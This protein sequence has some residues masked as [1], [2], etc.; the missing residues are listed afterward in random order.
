MSTIADWINEFKMT[1]IDSL[2]T[3]K[4]GLVILRQKD[5]V[6]ESYPEFATY[7]AMIENEIDRTNG[8]YS[9]NEENICGRCEYGETCRVHCAALKV[10]L[11]ED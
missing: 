9:N 5:I 4:A 6:Q 10:I 3:I 1:P 2:E 7:I 8:E 11:N